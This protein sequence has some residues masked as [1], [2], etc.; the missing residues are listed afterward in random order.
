M[1]TFGMS[2]SEEMKGK[3]QTF[4]KENGFTGEIFGEQILAMFATEELRQNKPQVAR[5]IQ[6]LQIDIN[7]IIGLFLSLNESNE[8][9]LDS[10]KEDCDRKVSEALEGKLNAEG[11]RSELQTSYEDLQTAYNNLMEDKA[12]AD[13][14]LIT[15]T[16]LVDNQKTIIKD[17]DEKISNLAELVS[18]YQEHEKAYAD[19][20]EKHVEL[21]KQIMQMQLTITEKES[22]INGMEL[23]EKQNAASHKAEVDH[24]KQAH[25]DEIKSLNDKAEL[26]KEK[27]LLE[28]DKTHQSEIKS[29]T[30]DFNKTI[31]EYQAVI[32]ADSER[33]NNV[34][35]EL[36]TLRIEQSKKNPPVPQKQSKKES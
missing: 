34:L 7:K 3:L 27:A 29:I 4:M 30:A 17:R 14:Q 33:Y 8:T 16:E 25:A 18:T 5:D 15:L 1:A 32:K 13:K 12:E 22:V 26:A 9:I 21:Q 11:E 2:C 24:I 6:A 10:L 31:A 23:T 35:E 19:L 36:N 20:K 28:V